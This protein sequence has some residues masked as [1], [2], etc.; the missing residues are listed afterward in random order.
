MAQAR[1]AEGNTEAATHNAIGKLYIRLNKDPQQF[2]LHNQFYDSIVVGEFCEKL[3]PY[4]AYLAYKRR[5]DDVELIE[6]TNVNGLFKDQARYLVERQD[7]DFVKQVLDDSNEYKRQLIDEVVGT[8]LPEN[9]NADAL[10]ATVKAFM[11]ASLPN[12][13]IELLEKSFYKVILICYK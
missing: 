4:L 11:D 6:V 5:N 9:E 8:A 10:G 12:E 2:L 13:L 1:I 3:D 7:F